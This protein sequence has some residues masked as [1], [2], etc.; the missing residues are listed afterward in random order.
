MLEKTQR[1]DAEVK[2]KELQLWDEALLHIDQQKEVIAK[3]VQMKQQ[4]LQQ[5]EQKFAR[6]ETEL[7]I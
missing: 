5:T 3:E 4:E 6:L 2:Q 7:S 1:L